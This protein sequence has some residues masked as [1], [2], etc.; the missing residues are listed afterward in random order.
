MSTLDPR[1]AAA[2]P[3]EGTPDE[4]TP[5]STRA[6][7]GLTRRAVVVGGA[8]A[9]V[10]LVAAC[11]SSSS[12]A[13]GT[14]AG[15]TSGGATSASP[16]PTSATATSSPGGTVLTPA[17]SVP[18]GGGVIV[19]AGDQQLVVTQPSAGVFEGFSAVCPHEGCT[20]NE[21]VDQQIVC[22]CHNSRFAIT[23]GAVESGPARTGLAP[24]AVAQ[25][26]ADIVLA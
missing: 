22:P 6:G 14:S 21:V 11:S 3:D 8:L 18:V 26:G 5:E 25:Q 24:V 20:C 13:G 2:T 4:A 15:V 16:S 17:A 12:S 7:S 9:G 19:S 1:P 23:D 10:G